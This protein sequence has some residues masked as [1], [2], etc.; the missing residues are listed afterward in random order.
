ME[1]SDITIYF[2]LLLNFALASACA[3]H[4]RRAVLH[5][6][7]EDASA[8]RRFT[9]LCIASSLFSGIAVFLTILVVFNVGTGHGTLLII[10]PVL[11]LLLCIVLVLL[12]RILV[13][14]EAMSW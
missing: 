10:G 7:L 5:Q 6:R 8:K 4:F 1:S 3:L 9:W 2:T 13:G 12:G 14:W 11:H